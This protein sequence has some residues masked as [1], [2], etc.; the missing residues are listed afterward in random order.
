MNFSKSFKL[1]KMGLRKNSPTILVSFGVTGTVLT[2]YLAGKASF[3]AA[4]ELRG[5]DLDTKESIKEV[6][7]LYIPAVISGVATIGFIVGAN[8]IS[9]KRAAAAYSVMAISE[10]MFEE[11]KEKVVEKLGERKEQEIR[12][13]IAQS[14]VQNNQPSSIVVGSGEVICC[15]LGT[16]RYFKSD[17]ETLR[18]AQND[19]NA[20]LVRE[21]YVPLSEFY[22]MVGLSPT[23]YSWDVGWVSEKHMDLQFTTVLTEDSK[24]CLAFEY[25]YIKPI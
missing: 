16:G 15:E 23:T 20:K 8:K 11:Y 3:K 6:F 4:D 22:Y 17:M 25:N 9:S 18:K 24:P 21:L 10:R 14:R 5:K 2:A 7:P 13:E 1:F 19:I 12:D